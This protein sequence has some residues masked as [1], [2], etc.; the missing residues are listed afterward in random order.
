MR[1]ERQPNETSDAPATAPTGISTAGKL[2][3]DD[4]LRKLNNISLK[5]FGICQPLCEKCADEHWKHLKLK[6][7]R[8]KTELKKFLKFQ[9]AISKAVSRL[10]SATHKRT[11]DR[12]NDIDSAAKRNVDDAEGAA[13]ERLADRDTQL[14]TEDIDCAQLTEELDA[15][16][17]RL[18]SVRQSLLQ[19]RQQKQLMDTKIK[20]LRITKEQYQHLLVDKEDALRG[21]LALIDSITMQQHLTQHK[22]ERFKQTSAYNDAFFIWH[23]GPFGTINNYKLGRLPTQLVEFDEINAAW[24]Q[25]AMLLAIVE[26][27]SFQLRPKETASVQRQAKNLVAYRVAPM[28]S[29]SKMARKGA[30]QKSFNLYWDGGW[31]K[32]SSYNQ[33][34]TAFLSCLNNLATFAKEQDPGVP[35]P[36]TIK[37]HKI[38]GR[39][40]RVSDK[41]GSVEW[42]SACK[43]VLTNLKWLVAWSIR[44]GGT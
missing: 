42:T 27:R 19:V 26:E 29:H 43:Y 20:A 30:E 39:S 17:A 33:G 7:E 2:T 24:G 15:A 22:L 41:N 13:E 23:S 3:I 8:T 32:R 21:Q 38:G 6:V 10:P 11:Q 35:I 37:D 9:Q 16:E 31:L 36:Y 25:A 12:P 40:I 1:N 14:A 34:M 28:G 44:N 18:R 4:V 5:E